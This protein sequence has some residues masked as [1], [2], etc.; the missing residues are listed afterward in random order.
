MGDA[1]AHL[2]DFENIILIACILST[3]ENSHWWLPPVKLIPRWSNKCLYL[4][5]L[6]LSSMVMLTKRLKGRY[7]D[8]NYNDKDDERKGLL[9]CYKDNI[10]DINKNHWPDSYKWW[11]ESLALDWLMLWEN[12]KTHWITNKFILF[13]N[14]AF[15]L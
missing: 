8:Q 7:D 13:I 1:L 2:S 9:W 4:W 3:D 11:R 15:H 5:C 12:Y 10:I 14:N 6:Y